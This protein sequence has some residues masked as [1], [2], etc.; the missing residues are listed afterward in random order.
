MRQISPKFV[1]NIIFFPNHI[2][3][4][5]RAL[6]KVKNVAFGAKEGQGDAAMSVSSSSSQCD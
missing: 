3:F 4:P 1:F 5:L 6:Q 2:I